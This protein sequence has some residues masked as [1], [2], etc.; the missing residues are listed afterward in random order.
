MY[1]LER[2]NGDKVRILNPQQVELRPVPIHSPSGFEYGYGGS[3]PAEAAYVILQDFYRRRWGTTP[4]IPPAMYQDF[5]WDV[6]AALDIAIQRHTL[7]DAQIESWLREHG[8][9]LDACALVGDVFDV[10]TGAKRRACTVHCVVSRDGGIHLI[11]APNAAAV[12][13]RAWSELP[14][15]RPQAAHGWYP[16]S[17]TLAQ[18]AGCE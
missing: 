9:A 6:I 11:P 14:V 3:G 8:W 12:E 15:L 4:E 17:T 16:I 1:V 13:E 7:D 18:A 5:K 2:I 10:E